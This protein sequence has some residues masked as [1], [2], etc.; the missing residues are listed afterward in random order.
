MITV[1]RC[2]LPSDIRNVQW[3]LCS[4][5]KLAKYNSFAVLNMTKTRILDV[6]IG[7]ASLQ[8]SIMLSPLIHAV[9]DVE[10]PRTIECSFGIIC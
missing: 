5:W 8:A 1:I 6:H 10:L 2:R 4:D 9:L 7:V 3:D